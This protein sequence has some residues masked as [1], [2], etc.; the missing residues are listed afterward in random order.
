M[1]VLVWYCYCIAGRWYTLH[2]WFWFGRLLQCWALVHTALL[3]LVHTALLA[4]VCYCY[5]S[6]GRWYTLQCWCWFGT[7]IALLG[8]GTHCTVG[9]GLLLLLRCRVQVHTALV[10]LVY[11]AFVMMVWYCYFSAGRR[12]T[13]H[14]WRWLGTV[15][16]VLGAGAHCIGGAALVLLLQCMAQVHTALVALVHTALVVLVWYC[17]CSSG[18]WYTLHCR[19]WFGPVIAMQGAA[20]E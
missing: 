20:S 5:Y 15:I 4:L 12:Y 19:R 17:Y 8:A 2:S 14:C 7:V 9:A 16:A 3:A 6:A 13:L 18:R 11:T 10:A 1:L